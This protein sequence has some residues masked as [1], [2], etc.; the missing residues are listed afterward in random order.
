M[1]ILR[2]ADLP[3]AAL[4]G[5]DYVTL[6][7]SENGLASLSVWRQRMEPGAATPPHSHDCEEV[8]IVESG[9]GEVHVDGRV[10]AFGPGTT[11]VIP[12]NVV[13]Q[14]FS[15]GDEPLVTTAA[16]SAT[17]VGV[18]LLDGAPLPLPWRS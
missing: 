12:P 1:Q 6:A 8:V 15:T 5:I 13:H 11:L 17:P 9:T 2:N 4:P 10:H 16:F 14:I 7:C 18:F 3:A